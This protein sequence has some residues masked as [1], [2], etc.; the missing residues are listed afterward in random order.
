MRPPLV[1]PV[2]P[3]PP[4]AF[5]ASSLARPGDVECPTQPHSATRL[6]ADE[7][8]AA[9]IEKKTTASI[10]A[11]PQITSPKAE[12]TRFVSTALR[13]CRENKGAT[14]AP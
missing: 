2:E 12:V 14:A 1:P 4:W 8:S 9:I 10:S 3:V 6:K 5:P 7:A 11:K 13:E